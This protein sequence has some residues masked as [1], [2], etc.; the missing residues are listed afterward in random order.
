MCVSSFS[1]THVWNIFHSTKNWARLI[2]KLY[3]GLH[4]KYPLLLS[5]FNETWIYLAD[6][7][8]ILK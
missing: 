4:V 5:D 1:T 6:L 3:I 8:K 7:R 2:K